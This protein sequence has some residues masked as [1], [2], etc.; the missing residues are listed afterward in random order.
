MMRSALPEQCRYSKEA[1]K[2][3]SSVNWLTPQARLSRVLGSGVGRDSSKLREH[4]NRTSP[5]GNAGRAWSWFAL[6]S[7]DLR[8]AGRS[9]RGIVNEFWSQTSRTSVLGKAGRACR[10]HPQHSRADSCGGSIGRA[11][12]MVFILKS[13][14]TR[15]CGR[16]AGSSVRSQPIQPLERRR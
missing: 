3:G 15:D 4:S 1:G 13:R 12:N 7:K 6:Q 2:A 10:L 8:D 16:S 11:D 9:G 14:A 5:G